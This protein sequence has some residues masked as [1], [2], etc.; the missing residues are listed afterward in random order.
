MG[1]R[2]KIFNVMGVHWKIQFLGR[3][4]RVHGKPIYGGIA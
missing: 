1:L 3:G 2:I 4:G